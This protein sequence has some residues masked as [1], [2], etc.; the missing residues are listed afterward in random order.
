MG[1]I[2]EILFADGK[3]AQSVTVSVDTPEDDVIS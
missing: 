3:R 2:K 1:N